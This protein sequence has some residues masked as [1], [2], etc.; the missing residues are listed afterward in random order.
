VTSGDERPSVDR[1]M[2]ARVGLRHREPVRFR[3]HDSQRW[4][5]GT[6]RGLSADGSLMIHDSDGAA[7]NL[8]PERVE[9]RRPGDRGR[10]TWQAVADVAVTWEQLGL[11]E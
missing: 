3:R 8:R 9:V 11:F 6:M 5:S 4:H 2:L 7:R 10:L 1:E